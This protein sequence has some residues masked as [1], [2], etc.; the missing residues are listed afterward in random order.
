[1]GVC[2]DLTFICGAGCKPLVQAAGPSHR[3][4]PLVKKSFGT[5]FREA[6]DAA[7]VSKSAHGL[8]K[9]GATRAADNRVTLPELEAI[10]GWEGGGMAAL[11]TKAYNRRKRA[12]G[13]VNKLRKNED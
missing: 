5:M 2:G 13:A 10:F 1:M 4:K 12:V 9:V 8:R 11:C 6:C 3:S 7:G